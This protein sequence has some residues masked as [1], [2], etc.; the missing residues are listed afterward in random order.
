MT[1]ENAYLALATAKAGLKWRCQKQELRD[2]MQS[3]PLALA[4]DRVV[5]LPLVVA[6]TTTQRSPRGGAARLVTLEGILRARP[7]H[8][9]PKD[10][11]VFN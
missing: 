2:G 10:L 5:D 8:E 9:L 11:F 6:W 4:A 7:L 1:P 3:V